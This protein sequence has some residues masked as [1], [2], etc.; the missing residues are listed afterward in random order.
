MPK[1]QARRFLTAAQEIPIPAQRPLRAADTVAALLSRAQQLAE[2]PTG[3]A[4]YDTEMLGRAVEE[5]ASA[6][7]AVQSK[8]LEPNQWLEDFR[9]DLFSVN[10][11]GLGVEIL[12]DFTEV[13]QDDLD[14]MAMPL[15]Q[16]RRFKKR[17]AEIPNPGGPHGMAALALQRCQEA[18]AADAVLEWL[19]TLRLT[20]WQVPLAECGVRELADFAEVL[21]E[22]LHLMGL[23]PLQRRRYLTA[24]ARAAGAPQGT[25]AVPADAVVRAMAEKAADSPDCVQYLRALRLADY[26]QALLAATGLGCEARARLPS[27]S[28]VA[29]PRPLPRASRE[30]EPLRRFA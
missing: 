4:V 14:G 3:G 12:P 1:L 16:Q 28:L 30:R 20:A 9:L 11:D 24:A 26:A 10:F 19:R 6:A 21:E 23:P 25:P 13:T 5:V 29:S 2:L 22:E 17:A 8:A 15:L 7:S 18:R 27:W